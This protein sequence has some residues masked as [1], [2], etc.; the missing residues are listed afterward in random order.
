MSE[1]QYAHKS[2]VFFYI[3]FIDSLAYHLTYHLSQTYKCLP[4]PDLY[5]NSGGDRFPINRKGTHS[6]FVG[7][8]KIVRL[9]FFVS[10]ITLY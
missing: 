2:T 10:S 7:K 5:W 9:G 8:G 3:G 6:G 1:N 4:F